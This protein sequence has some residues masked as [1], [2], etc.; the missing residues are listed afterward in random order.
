VLEYLLRVRWHRR[1]VAPL[2]EPRLKLIEIVFLVD[3]LLNL[4]QDLSDRLLTLRVQRVV[5]IK[6]QATM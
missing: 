1:L 2:V 6:C 3:Q 5:G 4:A